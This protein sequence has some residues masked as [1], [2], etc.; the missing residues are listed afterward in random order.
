MQL[1]KTI[2]NEKKTEDS[3]A[4][5]EANHKHDDPVASFDY[6]HVHKSIIYVTI[7]LAK[8]T[9]QLYLRRSKTQQ[10]VRFHASEKSQ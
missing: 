9:H 10:V 5:S 3:D 7:Q 4:F 6:A 8:I 1:K 2:K